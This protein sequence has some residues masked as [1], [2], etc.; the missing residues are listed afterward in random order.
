M[1]IDV[2]DPA[3]W[4]KYRHAK[5]CACIEC[6]RKDIRKVYKK[7][8]CQKCKKT[9]VSLEAIDG[10]HKMIFISCKNCKEQIGKRRYDRYPILTNKER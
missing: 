7:D 9:G 10:P 3:N 2:R 1:K 4:K 8:I 6:V 5:L